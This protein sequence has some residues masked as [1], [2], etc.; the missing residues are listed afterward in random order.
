M[1]P[2]S[3]RSPS[4]RR[5]GVVRA[6]VGIGILIVVVLTVGGDAF[7]RGLTAVSPETA[8][9][10]VA[11]AA[12]GTAAAALRWRAI[13]GRLGVPIP[14]GAAVSAYYRSQLLNSFLPGGVL[15]DVDRAVAHGRDAG[16]IAQAA[17]AVAAE[18]V[19]GQAVQLVFA[20]SVLAVLGVQASVAL[21]GMLLA[22]AGAIVAVVALVAAGARVRR[23]VG[24][25]L[26]HARI[27]FGGARVLL[28]V[29]ATSIVVVA[30]HAAT[31]VVACLAVGVRA[32]A[33]Q[34]VSAALLTVLAGSIPLGIGGWGPREAVAAWTFTT[35]G[36]GASDAVAAS[37]AFG[38]LATIAVLPGA[39]VLAASVAR[40]RLVERRRRVNPPGALG[41]AGVPSSQESS[42]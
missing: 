23:I 41:A 29:V 19:G 4:R 25:E 38:V 22:V 34:L 40:V 3:V 14:F 24:R 21:D 5:R 33:P 27:A 39:A 37:T 28:D 26:A 11:L 17:R 9:A 18:R 42:A 20:A 16:R 35:L 31:F 6:A 15:G 2:L 8:A 36:L 32:S 1:A 13:A 10:A 12:L 30:C 7:R